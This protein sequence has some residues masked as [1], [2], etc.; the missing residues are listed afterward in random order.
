MFLL[1]STL[2]K[3]VEFKDKDLIGFWNREKKQR[4]QDNDPVEPTV[5]KLLLKHL[6][7]TF[8]LIFLSHLNALKHIDFIININH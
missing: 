4:N 7:F 6:Y 1:C 5:L 3:K 8:L 2:C